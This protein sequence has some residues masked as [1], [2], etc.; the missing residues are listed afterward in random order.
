MRWVL[1]VGGGLVILL[2]GVAIIGLLL[3][4]GHV[5]SRTVRLRQPPE[6]VWKAITDYEAFPSWRADVKRVERLPDRNGHPV[7]REIDKRGHAL[8]LEMVEAT[9][10]R[11]LVLRIADP[12]LP[13]GGVW[14]YEI[15]PADGG[16]AI[17]ITESGEIYNPV[18]R[19]L[20]R[21][22]FGYHATMDQY[23]KSLGKKFGEDVRIGG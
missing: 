16:S 18:F 9:A 12:K 1:V 15:A 4:K 6:A 22:V 8:P 5:A 14:T 7:W 20:A 17:T 3:P 19:F 11:R 23:L 2:G 13:F 10:P 21:F